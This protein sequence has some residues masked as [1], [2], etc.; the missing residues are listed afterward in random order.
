MYCTNCGTWNPDEARSCS[1][2]GSSMPVATGM[3]QEGTAPLVIPNH[4]VEAILVTLCCCVPF[5]I[6]AIV[7]GAQ[8]GPKVAAGDIQG[9]LDAS[10]KAKMWSWIGFGVGGAGVLLYLLAMVVGVL[11]DR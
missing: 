8:V 2:C 10:R 7:Y 4:L 6:P 5:G 11:A 3:G 1:Q 9:A